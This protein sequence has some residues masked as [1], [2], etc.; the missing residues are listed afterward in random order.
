MK[1]QK[2]P[3]RLSQRSNW[4]RQQSESMKQI[5][6]N[7]TCAW[8]HKASAGV[9]PALGIWSRHALNL[10]FLIG[11]PAWAKKQDRSFS[12]CTCLSPLTNWSTTS[13]YFEWDSPGSENISE[14]APPTM[15]G[16][17]L[18]ICLAAN[19]DLRS[20]YRNKSQTWKVK[21]SKNKL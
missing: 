21:W 11:R 6:P 8:K 12:V 3:C 2:W 16:Y 1:K 9:R 10:A 13:Q 18:Y 17:N 19:K 4:G 20:R 7:L 15:R 5:I 14:I